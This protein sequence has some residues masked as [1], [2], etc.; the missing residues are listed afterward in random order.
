MS[1]MKILDI[2]LGLL[3][4]FNSI[5]LVDDIHRPMLLGSNS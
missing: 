2:P 1:Y 4:N 3:M 5:K